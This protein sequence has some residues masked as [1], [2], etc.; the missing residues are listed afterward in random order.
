MKILNNFSIRSKTYMLVGLSVFVALTLSFVSNS[1]LNIIEAQVDELIRANNV[2]RYA[3]HAI[4]EEKRYLLN[5]NGSVTNQEDARQASISLQKA[6]DDIYNTLENMNTKS[7][8]DIRD[9]VR[10]YN[11]NYR[12]GVY[13]L[14]ELENNSKTLQKEGENI[15]FEI[16]QY[17]EVKRI[18]AEQELFLSHSERNI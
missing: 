4:L 9:A 15:T 2:E 7:T 8:K 6:V 10:D 11:I 12:R 18:K 5:S 17:I 1:G 16:Q 3:Y 14:E 13:L